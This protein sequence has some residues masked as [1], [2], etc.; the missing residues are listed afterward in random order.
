MWWR[1]P[2]IRNVDE[3]RY[4][5]HIMCMRSGP[6][7]FALCDVKTSYNKNLLIVTNKTQLDASMFCERCL[8]KLPDLVLEK[9]ENDLLGQNIAD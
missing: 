9:Q 2:L 7:Y 3:D 1:I 6:F 5:Y 4:R 8:M